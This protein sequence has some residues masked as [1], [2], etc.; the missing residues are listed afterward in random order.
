[1]VKFVSDLRVVGDFLQVVR[2]PPPIVVV[3]SSSCFAHSGFITGFKIRVTRQVR[4]VKQEMLTIT[5]NLISP[6]I[7]FLAWL[8]S[9]N[10][11]FSV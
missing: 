10:H 5:E 1:M 9:L 4:L 3:I 8:A 7:F 11:L 6:S 2:F